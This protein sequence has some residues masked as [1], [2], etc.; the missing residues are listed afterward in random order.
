[1][2][3]VPAS[4]PRL[5]SA[6]LLKDLSV[7]KIDRD[8]YPIVAVG[9]RGYYLNSMGKPGV[10]DIGDFDDAFI[11][12]TPNVMMS[13]NGNTDPTARGYGRAH[14][15][16]GFWP[17]WK[18]DLHRGK[19]LAFCQRAA[20]CEVYRDGTAHLPV[21]TQNDFGLHMGNGIWRGWFG[22]NGHKAGATTSSLGCQT[23]PAQQWPALIATAEAEARRFAG[24]KWR[25]LVIPYVLIEKAR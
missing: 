13:C 10:N 17:M 18:L 3:S 6:D 7:H 16:P 21:G 12:H 15:R 19:Y 9:Y 1:M 4:R 8:K 25:S 24:A 14:L 2:A 23:V 20:E 22:I 5:S 11:L